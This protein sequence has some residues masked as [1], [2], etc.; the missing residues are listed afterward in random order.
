MGS[1]F[2]SYS[3][4][5]KDKVD[6]LAS[7]LAAVGRPVWIDRT[8]IQAG[9]QWRR[10]IVEAIRQ[11]DALILVLSPEAVQSDNVRKELDLAEETRIRII[12]AEIRPVTIPPQMQ[13]Q[14]A[15][16]QR[17]NLYDDFE[18]GFQQLL[19][20]LGGDQGPLTESK[21]GQP[22]PRIR[23]NKRRSASTGTLVFYTVIS[24][25]LLLLGIVWLVSDTE[26]G[27]GPTCL[28][29]ILLIF[30]IAGWVSWKKQ[31]KG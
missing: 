7:K 24:T 27:I 25:G 1:I 31:K 18:A 10:Q 14:L 4:T 29:S 23:F 2:L 15:G 12:P 21:A 11:A 5:D 8:S 9:D 6:L 28:G 13:Y 17:I 20:A 22:R 19:N 26:S 3:R 16:I 30:T